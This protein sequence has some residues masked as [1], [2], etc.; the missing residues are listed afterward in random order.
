[1]IYF[2]VASELAIF[3]AIESGEI[4]SF[5]TGVYKCI[6][7]AAIGKKGMKEAT[8]PSMQG[9]IGKPLMSTIMLHTS[10]LKKYKKFTILCLFTF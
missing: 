3:L 4:N 8:N 10:F 9:T 6:Q 1:M 2:V 7:Q 5:L